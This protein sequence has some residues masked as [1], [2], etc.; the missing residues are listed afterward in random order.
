[1]ST[2]STSCDCPKTE[3]QYVVGTCLTNHLAGRIVFGLSRQAN[4]ENLPASRKVHGGCL[5]VIWTARTRIQPKI[6][7]AFGAE[8]D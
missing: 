5:P 8:S 2:T 7:V 1:M 4:S 3:A 6:Q